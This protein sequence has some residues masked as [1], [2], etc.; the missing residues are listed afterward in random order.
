MKCSCRKTCSTRFNCK[1]FQFPCIEVFVCSGGCWMLNKTKILSSTAC[2][3]DRE[4][5]I[6]SRWLLLFQ[7]YYFLKKHTLIYW[8][9]FDSNI[10][11]IIVRTNT[12]YLEPIQ[13]QKKRRKTWLFLFQI[14]RIECGEIKHKPLDYNNIQRYSDHNALNIYLR[15]SVS[16]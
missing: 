7:L 3:W 8:F 13:A 6:T 1:K 11:Q 15:F 5:D 4:H 12:I 16:D 9:Y 2:Y 14:L 10:R